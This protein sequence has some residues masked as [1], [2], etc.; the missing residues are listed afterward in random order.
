MRIEE[1]PGAQNRL[2]RAD[3]DLQKV[4][5]DPSRFRVTLE[6]VN[7][8]LGSAGNLEEILDKVDKAGRDLLKGQGVAELKAYR[9]AVRKF[10]EA[11][12]RQS[13]EMKDERR[14][15][16]R[17]NHRE[18]KLIVGINQQLEEL[19]RMVL[20]AQSSSMQVLS[21]LDEI[22]GLLVDLMI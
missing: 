19:A 21:K 11:T 15:D 7:N 5:L 17:G 18:Y 12:V 16:R 2:G 6:M 8:Q 14:W 10:L 1:Y 13:F 22:R 3:T 20:E 9:E 4:S